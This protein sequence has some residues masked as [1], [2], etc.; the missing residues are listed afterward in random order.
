M[1]ALVVLGPK[2]VK[3]PTLVFLPSKKWKERRHDE[4]RKDLGYSD[5]NSQDNS[6]TVLCFGHCS[7]LDRME[8]VLDPRESLRSDHLADSGHPGIVSRI[9]RV[10]AVVRNMSARKKGT[11][12]ASDPSLLG[13]HRLGSLLRTGSLARRDKTFRKLELCGGTKKELV[14]NCNH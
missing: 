7:H 14:V 13:D 3:S 10:R 8:I 12:A 5:P 9:F 11:E 6:G 1:E 4:L 2:I